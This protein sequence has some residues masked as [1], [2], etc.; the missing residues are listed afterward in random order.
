MKRGRGGKL[1]SAEEKKEGQSYH[2]DVAGDSLLNS[3][4]LNENNILFWVEVQVIEPDQDNICTW[5]IK[6]YW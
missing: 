2:V 6:Y 5:L 1:F 4:I 3:Q